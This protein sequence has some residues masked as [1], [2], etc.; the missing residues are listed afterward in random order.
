[1]WPATVDTEPGD[2][3]TEGVAALVAWLGT[4]TRWVPLAVAVLAGV[5]VVKVVSAPGASVGYAQTSPRLAFLTLAGGFAMVLAGVVHLLQRRA[6]T[7]VVLTGL[8][9][10]AWFAPTWIGWQQAPDLARSLAESLAVLLMPTVLLLVV[11]HPDRRLSSRA[12]LASSLLFAGVVVTSVLVA[13]FRNPYLDRGCWANCTTNVFLV[14]EH[15]DLANGV[16]AVQRMLIAAAC[17]ALVIVAWS[18]STEPVSR[19]PTTR[20]SEHCSR[21]PPSRCCSS[22]WR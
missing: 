3:N 8:A 7:V 12:G 20:S 9:A 21:C 19:T 17:L 18:R 2:Q 6:S 5:G 15:P 16:E 13:L 22:G 1:M 14:S 4:V 10:L 11:L